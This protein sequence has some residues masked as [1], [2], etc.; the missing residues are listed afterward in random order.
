M[1]KQSVRYVALHILMRI[2]NEGGFSHL[3]ISQAIEQ[4]NIKEMDEKLLTEM[5][6][7]TLEH[8]LTLDY[9][10]APYIEKQ[11]K[12]ADW[13]RMLLRMSVFQLVYLD[14]VPDYARSEEHTSELQSRF[15]L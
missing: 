4:H 12:L 14:K 11:K 9:Y 5:V 2:E 7:G 8:K 15:V 10:L 13:V 6:Y 3:L 1:N